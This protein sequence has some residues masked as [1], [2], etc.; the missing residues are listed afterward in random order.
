MVTLYNEVLKFLYNIIHGE[1]VQARIVDICL[2]QVICSLLVQ[3]GS[4]GNY[5]RTVLSW[6]Q[7]RCQWNLIEARF[8]R[9]QTHHLT[10]LSPR[11]TQKKIQPTVLPDLLIKV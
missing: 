9:T 11:S 7:Y 5:E 8:S 3:G 4:I 10:A 2:A 6:L 1:C